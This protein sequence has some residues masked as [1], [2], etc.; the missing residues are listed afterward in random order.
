VVRLAP[1]LRRDDVAVIQLDQPVTGVP[2]VALG[3][4]DAELAH[5]LGRGTPYAPGT[6]HGESEMYDSTLRTADLKAIGD[7]DCARAFKGYKGATGERF[8]ARMRC[9]LDADGREPLYSGC[10]GD[11]GAPLWTGTAQAPVQLGVVSWGGDG[12]GADHLPSVFADVARYRDFITDPSPTWAPTR[13]GRAEISGTPRV[14]HK[15][16]CAAPGYTPEAGAKLSYTW[17]TT[18]SFSGGSY[19][20]PKSLGGGRTYKIA[21]ADAGR[22]VAC[23]ADASN[24]GGAV[25]VGVD[26]TLI[27]RSGA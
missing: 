11:S 10:F 14:G 3:G 18:G 22:R 27:K 21:K 4:V 25:H 23:Q 26:N 15:L 19:Q 9:S 7:K 24:D 12:C 2:T 8:D 13:K 16:T 17:T 1:Q 5:I 6:G 20:P